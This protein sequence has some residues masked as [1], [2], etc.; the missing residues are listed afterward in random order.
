M[1]TDLF[2][3]GTTLLFLVANPLFAQTGSLPTAAPTPPLRDPETSAQHD[4]R[5]AWWREAKFGMFIHWGLYAIPHDGEYRMRTNKMPVAEYKKFAEQFNAEK[6]NADEWATLAEEAGMKYVVFTAKYYDGFAMFH[7]QASDYNIYDATS[8]KR[9]PLKELS[10][11][12][13][14]HGLK[15]GT[16]YSPITDWSHPGGGSNSPKWDRAQKGDLDDHINRVS[17]PQLQELLA[18]YGPIAVMWFD[19]DGAKPN[20]PE[21]V[22]RFA[23]VLKL[24][25]EIIVSTRLHGYPGDFEVIQAHVPMQ[26]PK[27]DWELSTRTNGSWG[28]TPADA[29]LLDSLLHELIEAWGKGGNVLLNV[30]PTEDGVIPYGS[31]ARLREIGEWLK[32]NGEAVYGSKRGPFDYLPWG[33]STLKDDMLY[34]FVF[35]WPQDGK[36][37]VPMSTPVER[38]WLLADKTKTVAANEA[39]GKTVFELPGQAPDRAASVIAV[40]VKGKIP[41]YRSL[42]LNKPVKASENQESAGKAVDGGVGGYW[43][44]PSQNGTLEVDMGAPQ[45]FNTFRLATPGTTAQFQLEVKNGAEWKTVYKETD[46]KGN[47]WVKTF[48]TIT[49]QI[50]RLTITADKPDIRVSVFELFPPL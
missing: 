45:A 23:P 5:M 8:F 37:I 19:N 32:I 29:R 4:A 49:G 42:L 25:P 17:L 22:A 35:N 50:V 46:P 21:Q 26:P 43:R 3:A 27:K 33:W 9:D 24:Q 16:S 10:E 28:Y 40:K 31:A 48:P 30:G 7:S 18:N 12:C 20:T 13:P 41:L 1:N 39:G 36:L 47:D 14:K 38:A 34:L 44:I 15:L 11:A 2:A 6:F